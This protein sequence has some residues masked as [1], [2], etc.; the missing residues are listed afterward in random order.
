MTT[1]TKERTRIDRTDKGEWLSRLLEDVETDG[2]Y[3]PA[4]IA[5]LRMRTRLFEGMA[6][7]VKKAA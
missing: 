4:P 6:E 7:P 3:A 2:S 5:V 1:A